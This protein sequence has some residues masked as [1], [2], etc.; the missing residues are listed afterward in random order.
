MD[1]VTLKV[2][3]KTLAEISEFYF[4]LMEV[5]FFF[6]EPNDAVLNHWSTPP[7][8]ILCITQNMY[9]YLEREKKK[10]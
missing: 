5:F 4:L 8:A 3:L 7:H 9:K 2:K 1:S 10:I 6:H